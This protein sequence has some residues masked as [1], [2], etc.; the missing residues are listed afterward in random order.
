[1]ILVIAIITYLHQLQ[2][3]VQLGRLQAG[4][5]G[6][7]AQV[8]QQQLVFR[9]ALNWLDQE[10][11]DALPVSELVLDLLLWRSSCFFLFISMSHE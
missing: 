11:V 3:L 9:D 4:L 7:L 1:M 6:R 8:F 2:S 5:L 10:R